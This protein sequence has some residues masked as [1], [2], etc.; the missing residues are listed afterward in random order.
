MRFAGICLFPK[1]IK[2]NELQKHLLYYQQRENNAKIMKM[3]KGD[4]IYDIVRQMVFV[5]SNI[6]MSHFIDKQGNSHYKRYCIKFDKKA[7]HKR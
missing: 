1:R 5:I 6:K 7:Y 3:K 2:N 4:I